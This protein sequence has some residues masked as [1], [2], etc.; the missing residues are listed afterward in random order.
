MAP[1]TIAEL[2]EA[3]RAAPKLLAVGAGTKPRLAASD[4]V[5]LCISKLTGILEYEPSEFTF[6]ALAGTP[7]REIATALDE[8]GQYMPFDPMCVGAG[9]TLGGTVASGLSGPGRFRYGGVRD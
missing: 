5:K 2:V 8:K 9:A 6:T 3:V 4:A 7:V 1:E